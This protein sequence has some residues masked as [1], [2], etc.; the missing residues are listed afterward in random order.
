MRG[1][2]RERDVDR[3]RDIITDARYRGSVPQTWNEKSR[4]NRTRRV[5]WHQTAVDSL[6][7]ETDQVSIR[8]TNGARLETQRIL[9]ATGFSSKR[10]GGAL[11]DRLVESASLPCASCGYPII[12][13]SLRWHPRV[14]VTGPL[15]E[16]ELGP[17]SRNI[18]G[19]RRAGERIL[20][21]A[22]ISKNLQ[23]RQLSTMR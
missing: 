12:D 10:P 2:R 13:P 22:R 9:L 15:A 17:S 7:I 20:E 14:H 3:R 4:G 18:A 21:A 6:D 11:V 23:S 19:A 1:F 5:Y 8:L 16:L